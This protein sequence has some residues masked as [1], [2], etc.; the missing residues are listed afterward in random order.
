M[1]RLIVH[2]GTGK[3]GSTAIQRYLARRRDEFAKYGIFYWGLNLEHAVSTQRFSWQRPDGIGLIQR[4]PLARAKSELGSAL[5]EAFQALESGSTAVWCNESIYERPDL[6]IP[7]LEDLEVEGIS[8]VCCYAYARN[9]KDY[10]LS[11]YKQW[12]VK[13]KTYSGRVQGFSEWAYSR[14]DFLAYGKKLSVWHE[15]FGNRYRTFN[16][17]SVHDVLEHF[18]LLL[19]ESDKLL[20]KATIGKANCSPTDIPLAL[21]ALYN[22]QFQDPVLPH[23]VGSVLSRYKLEGGQYHSPPLAQLYPSA[24]ELDAAKALLTEDIE[25]IDSMLHQNNQPPLLSDADSSADHS[26]SEQDAFRGVLALLLSI[27]VK[28]DQRID[29][30]ERSC[31]ASKT[32]ELPPPP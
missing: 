3:T 31:T 19:P 15:A 9:T 2:I 5:N 25:L 26:L 24:E 10:I 23:G 4:M 8:E 13:H 6:Y 29:L 16:Y 28:Q 1:K 30:L 14:K 7:L 18:L 11:A 17:D 32:A 22:N 27:I 20:P 21:Y 12:G